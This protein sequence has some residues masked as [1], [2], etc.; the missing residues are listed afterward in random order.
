MVKKTKPMQG[1]FDMPAD[2]AFVPD[3][4]DLIDDVLRRVIEMAPNFSAALAHQISAQVRHDWAGDTIFYIRKNTNSMRNSRDQAIK[5][6]WQRGEHFPLLERRYG[7]SE[8]RVRQ[9][10]LQKD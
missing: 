2:A 9:I 5:R 10:L 4:N 3:E 6:D 8:R 7:L 1:S